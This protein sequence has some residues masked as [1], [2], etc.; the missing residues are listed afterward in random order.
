[1]CGIAGY[2]GDFD[3]ALLQ[4]MNEAIA[5]RGPDDSG[6]LSFPDARIGLAHRRLSIID[7]SPRGHQPM[8]DVTGRVTIVYN[9]EIYN[10]RELRSELLQDGYGFQSDTDTEVLLNLYLRDGEKLVER[11]NGIFAFAIHDTR[12]DSLLLVRDGLGVKPLYY[13]ET[14]K[15]FLFASEI[16]ALLQEPTVD[17]SLDPSAIWHHLLFL[18]NPSP[19]SML[20]SVRKLE[21]GCA[22]RVENGRVARHWRHYELPYDQ[23]PVEWPRGDAVVQVRK[24]L[25]RAVERQLVS[26]VPVGAFLSGGLDSSGVVALAQRA[27]GQ[28]RLQ[29]FTIGFDDPRAK[30]EGM[31]E[32]LPYARRVA[33]HLD[34]DLHTIYVGPEMVEE[35]PNVIYMLDEPQADPAP[36]NALFISRLARQH[37][38]KVLLSGAGGDDIFTGYR[39]HYALLQEPLWSWLPVGA[40]RLMRDVSGR[41]RPTNEFRRRVSKAMRHADLDE[42][43][44]IAAYFHWIGSA[45]LEDVLGPALRESFHGGAS[46]VTDTLAGLP[47]AVPRLHRMLYLESRYFLADHNLNYVDK[48]SMASGVEVRVP[49]L[50]PD[51][52]A[53]AARLP[54]AY[55]QRG[56]VGKW[57]LREAMRSY[58]P[59]EVLYRRKTGFGAPLRHWLRDELR[60]LVDELLGEEALARR[61][62]FDPAGVR[63]MIARDRALQ[64][65]AS[66]TI[67]SMMCIELWCRMFV[68]KPTPGLEGIA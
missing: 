28:E 68:D 40:R 66:Y 32:D 6:T 55:K 50:D 1:M 15:G 47:P 21:P 20:R 67:F 65:D 53:L 24:Q 35:L 62:L 4:R 58:L 12:D 25:A 37:G 41:I 59:R 56:R 64:S 31:A 18:W 49:I 48:V 26:D 16:K 46:P 57:V 9:G 7:L 5:H 17:R 14:P 54:P 61:G 52:V 38:I 8:T 30:A 13:A 51:L 22:L 23:E 29:C 36:I 3:E 63:T 19:L 2:S 43:D 27:M 45:Q 39:R 44:R 42:D 11:L 34:T 60:P 33:T 10:Y